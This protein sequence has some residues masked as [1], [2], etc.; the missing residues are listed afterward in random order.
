MVGNNLFWNTRGL[1]D[2]RE[3]HL[4]FFLA[5]ALECDPRFRRAY[6]S[7]VLECMR[8]GPAKPAIE[9]VKT[10]VAFPTGTPDLLLELRGG[11]RV[12]CEHKL[13]ARETTRVEPETRV[14]QK[15]LERYL[16]LGLDGVAY[17]RPTLT[18][19]SPEVVA[20]RHYIRPDGQQHFLWRDLYRP[21]SKGEHAITRWLLDGF[22]RL[23]FTP[24]VPHVGELWG[25]S[26]EVKENQRNFGKLWNST[27]GHAHAQWT[28]G[29]DS[30]SGLYLYPRRSGICSRVQVSP[31]GPTASILRFRCATTPELLP[32]VRVILTRGPTALPYPPEVHE[33]SLRSGQSCVDLEVPLDVLLEGADRADEQESRLQA[34]VVPLLDALTAAKKPRRRSGS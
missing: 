29:T 23:G 17:F 33:R 28:V 34:Q 14:M 8:D 22:R 30:R 24:P 18:T 7:V 16:G 26:E 21:L 4:T 19:L 12:A 9:A 6:A 31:T 32:R 11:R 5:A 25:D 15:Q 13:D 20:D 10:Q 3:D 27:R 1:T 2:R